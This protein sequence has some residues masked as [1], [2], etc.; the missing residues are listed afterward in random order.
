MRDVFRFAAPR[1]VLGRL[2]EVLLL[3]RNMAALLQERN[4]VIKQVAESNEW[5]QYLLA[6]C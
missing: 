3:K 6:D 4:A 1:G 2:A 5:R